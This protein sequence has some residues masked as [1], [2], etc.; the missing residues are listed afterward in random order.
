MDDYAHAKKVFEV[1]K[2]ETMMDYTE[3]YCLL[4]VFLLA[5]VMIAFRKEILKEAG[6]DCCQYISL[7]QLSFDMMLKLTGVEIELMTDIDQILFV[8]NGIRGGQSFINDRYVNIGQKEKDGRH[9][10]LEYIDGK[11]RKLKTKNK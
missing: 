1:L 8:E 2:C 3:F 7:P 11:M 5:E 6:L 9:R 10:Y 4:D